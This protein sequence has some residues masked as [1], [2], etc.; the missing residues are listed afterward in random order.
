M[1]S[2]LDRYIQIYILLK[3]PWESENLTL[4]ITSSTRWGIRRR[5][6]LEWCKFD[7]ETAFDY[8][9]KADKI[10]TPLRLNNRN[11]NYTEQD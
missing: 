9:C 4:S 7:L 3:D 5:N 8:I 2:F 10:H 1:D 11:I 6:I